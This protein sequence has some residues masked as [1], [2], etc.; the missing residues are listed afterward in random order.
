M[1]SNGEYEYGFNSPDF[2]I[3]KTN[4]SEPVTWREKPHIVES[5]SQIKAIPTSSLAENKVSA[6]DVF[7][8]TQTNHVSSTFTPFA[9]SSSLTNSSTTLIPIASPT[10]PTSS[11]HSAFSPTAQALIGV[12]I[13]LS[14]SLVLA[15][16]SIFFCNWKRWSNQQQQQQ[17]GLSGPAGGERTHQENN[18]RQKQKNNTKHRRYPL[19]ELA[20]EEVANELEGNRP[21]YEVE[22]KERKREIL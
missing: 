20:G 11:D 6:S 15:I 8:K 13:V 17:Q 21:V 19:S 4:A 7:P 22:G 2:R 14:L 5:T 12:V 1:N 3:S 16:I 18:D 10:L 9:S